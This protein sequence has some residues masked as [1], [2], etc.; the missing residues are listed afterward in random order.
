M[1]EYPKRDFKSNHQHRVLHQKMRNPMQPPK[2]KLSPNFLLSKPSS[3]FHDIYVSDTHQ[4]T[5]SDD[6]TRKLKTAPRPKYI[7]CPSP[8]PNLRIPVPAWENV[9]YWNLKFQR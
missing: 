5:V 7:P 2:T 8:N 6:E 1:T 3:N 4:L 9:V